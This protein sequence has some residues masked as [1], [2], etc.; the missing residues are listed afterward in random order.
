MK[1]LDID[2]VWWDPIRRASSPCSV[3]FIYIL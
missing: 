1:N 2:T 3:S